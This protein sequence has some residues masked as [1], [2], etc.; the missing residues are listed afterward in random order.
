[1]Q[2]NTTQCLCLGNILAKITFY[3][4]VLGLQEILYALL[5]CSKVWN[6]LLL[7]PHFPKTTHL[8]LNESII[9]G[10]FLFP[11]EQHFWDYVFPRGHEKKIG[12]I[13][14]LLTR[15]RRVLSFCIFFLPL[16]ESIKTLERQKCFL[17]VL[18]TEWKPFIQ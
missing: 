1:M 4:K 17:W 10:Q 6:I 15:H 9:V 8:I 2:S 11:T 12:N 14:Y 7:P 5:K 16:N 3:Y 13:T 18:S